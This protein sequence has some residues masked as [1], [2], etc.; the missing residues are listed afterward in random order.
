MAQNPQFAK[1][2]FGRCF[3]VVAIGL[4]SADTGD[5]IAATYLREVANKLDVDIDDIGAGHA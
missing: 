5:E 3:L 2:D 1:A 4:M